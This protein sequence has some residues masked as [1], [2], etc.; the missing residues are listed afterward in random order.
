MIDPPSGVS[1]SPE[2]FFFKMHLDRP[3]FDVLVVLGCPV[4]S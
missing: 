1:L 3:R 4:G 2:L